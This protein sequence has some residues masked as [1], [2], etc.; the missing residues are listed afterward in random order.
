[1]NRNNLTLTG[2]LLGSAL[3]ALSACSSDSDGD[4]SSGTPE[5]LLTTT[6]SAAPQVTDVDPAS[7]EM[8]GR[9]VFDVPMGDD[10]MRLCVMGDGSVT[11]SG[12]AP[13]DAPD[14]TIEPFG[15][16]RP[17]AIT[18]DDRGLTW[19]MLEGVPPAPGQLEPSRRITDGDLTCRTDAEGSLDC[20][21]G[22]NG[23]TINHEDAAIRVRGT[24]R[25]TAVPEAPGAASSTPT[26][27]AGGV[28][29]DYRST[30]EP[31]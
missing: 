23:F 21:L 30:D 11:C 7:F 9:Y 10:T 3:F 27:V 2:A 1:M 22:D 18:L 12:K 28:D 14:V 5:P 6:T 13:E 31:V 15:T 29:G 8:D 26:T 25:V 24:V 4:G 20:T 19:Y 17:T 16:Q